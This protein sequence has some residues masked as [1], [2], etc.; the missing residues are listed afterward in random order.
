[1]WKV[2]INIIA[3]Y[4]TMELKKN[5]NYSEDPFNI[6]IIIYLQSI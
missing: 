6:N 2:I 1:M 3:Y 4:K 5:T